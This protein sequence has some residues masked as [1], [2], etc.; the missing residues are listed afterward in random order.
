MPNP[1]N[2]IVRAVVSL[3]TLVGVGT[4][5]FRLIE[6][7]SWFDCFYF[8]LYTVATIGYGE[9]ATIGQHGRY[10]TVL[11]II[12][13]VGTV[14]YAVSLLTQFVIQGELQ[15]TLEKR[16]LHRQIE[17]L[18]DHYIVCGAGRIGERVAHGLES[19]GVPF[20]VVERDELLAQRLAAANV[21]VLAG[22]ATDED[23]LLRAG[24]R[25]AKG[26]VCALPSD[27]ENVYITLTARDLCTS[28]YIVARATDDSAIPKMRKAGADRIVSTAATGAH[29]ITQALLRPTV[30][31]FIE[32]AT[33]TE[34]LDLVIEEVLITAGS[35]LAGRTL[36]DA[37]LRSEH[38]I[39][40][41]TIKRADGEMIFNPK[42]GT[43]LN[44]GD[45]VIAVG[46]RASV[47]E[48]ARRAAAPKANAQR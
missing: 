27:A 31:D 26:L 8:T 44:A 4:I 24:I 37:D 12:A 35:S 48:L 11:L 5:G 34:G 16:R 46:K 43:Y 1:R 30:A 32:L 2:R 40:V 42:G 15:S 25:R 39:I 29:Q 6:G 47:D 3:V 13:G 17:A 45:R 23:V 41:I 19:E 28:I 14:G 38:N 7:W 33:K 36:V 22:D 21:L 9:P 10:F 20:L 18:T